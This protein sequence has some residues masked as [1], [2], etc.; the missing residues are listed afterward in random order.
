[1]TPDFAAFLEETPA[2]ALDVALPC[3]CRGVSYV[4]PARLMIPIDLPSLNG[5]TSSERIWGRDAA[6]ILVPAE[7]LAMQGR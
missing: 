4:S 5:T 2:V 1:M 6:P 7:M 3:R